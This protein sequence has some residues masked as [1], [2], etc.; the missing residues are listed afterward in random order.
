MKLVSFGRLM[1]LL[2]LLGLVCQVF[3]I[4]P[5]TDRKTRE[6]ISQLL[7]P[8]DD[9]GWEWIIVDSGNT[10][11]GDGG[12]REETEDDVSP[13]S[14][15]ATHL[16]DAEDKPMLTLKPSNRDTWLTSHMPAKKWSLNKPEGAFRLQQVL[17]S[18]EGTVWVIGTFNGSMNWRSH[19]I[20]SAGERDLFIAK[21]SASGDISWLRQVGS[22]Q[23]ERLY[24][25]RMLENA[26]IQIAIR[27]FQGSLAMDDMPRV[28]GTDAYLLELDETGKM[29]WVE[30]N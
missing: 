2:W 9:Y 12:E 27:S 29:S 28:S 15:R 3:A 24:E 13:K 23:D 20:Q 16:F 22:P 21:V 17:A 5:E 14:Q 18:Y 7:N 19:S 4:E 11:D 1:G 8:Y 6:R 25:A 10:E 26:R 30:R